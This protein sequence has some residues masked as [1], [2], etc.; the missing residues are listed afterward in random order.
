MRA[1]KKALAIA[2]KEITSGN[3]DMMILDEINYAVNFGLISEQEL[4]ELLAKRPGNLHLVCTG[5]NAPDVLLQQADLITEMKKIRHPFES[6]IK[7]QKG[8]EF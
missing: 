6:G 8:I 1:A 4:A 5:R 3:W 7:A 2:E